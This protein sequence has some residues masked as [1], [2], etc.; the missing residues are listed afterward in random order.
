MIS[1]A[2]LILHSIRVP[3]MLRKYQKPPQAL[4]CPTPP[5]KW[6]KYPTCI[7]ISLSLAII[8]VGIRKKLVKTS[9]VLSSH[10]FLASWHPLT[11]VVPVLRKSPWQ[12]A[13]AWLWHLLRPQLPWCN[14]NRK[15]T[16]LAAYRK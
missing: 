12:Q 16:D 13:S 7:Q 2:N 4:A 6:T 15:Y 8:S 10:C 14:K 11:S 1:F 3:G 9:H 5:K